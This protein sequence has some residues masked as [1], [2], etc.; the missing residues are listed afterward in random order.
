[1]ASDHA[2]E[3]SAYFRGV[4][5]NRM[6]ALIH[7]LTDGAHLHSH[8]QRPKAQGSTAR[9]AAHSSTVVAELWS[10]RAVPCVPVGSKG[11][12]AAPPPIRF[13]NG[14]EV[15]CMTIPGC[16][17]ILVVGLLGMRQGLVTRRRRLSNLGTGRSG[18]GV[19]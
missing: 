6:E 15:C 11:C 8:L 1:M 3:P 13:S 10:Y 4:R 5:P 14:G 18:S 9:C 7:A 17:P 16:P 2:R 19:P 12:A